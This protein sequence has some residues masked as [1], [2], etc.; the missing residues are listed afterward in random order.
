[1]DLETITDELRAAPLPPNDALRAAV[2]HAAALAPLVLDRLERFRL[3]V[4]LLPGDQRLLLYG[5]HVLAAARQQELWPHL[6]DLARAPE[7]ELADLFDNHAPITLARLM[8]SVWDGDGA[9]LLN[10]IEHADMSD[11]SKWALFDMLAQLTFDGRVPRETT[12]AFLARYERDGLVDDD[13]PL[14]WGWDGCVTRLGLVELEDALHRVWA[15]PAYA[16]LTPGDRESSVEELRRAAASPA[17]PTLFDTI[18]LAP[19]DDPALALEWMNSRAAI[20]GSW[21]AAEPEPTIEDAR[22]PA[23]GVRLSDEELAWLGRFLVSRQVPA[24]TMTLDMLDGYLTAATIGPVARSDAELLKN[25]WSEDEAAAPQWDGDDQQVHV[26][27]LIERHCRAI[28]LRC[29]ASSRHAPFI[30]PAP[31]NPDQL[32]MGWVDGFAHAL[33]QSGEA[34]DPLFADR[35]GAEEALELL[36]LYPDDREY[37]GR[38]AT[39]NEKARIVERLPDILK[40]IAAYWRDPARRYP[41]SV[42][43]R[44]AKTGR[45]D[46]C[47]CGSGKKYKKCCAQTPPAL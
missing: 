11:D 27:G 6:V 2:V 39:A 30:P 15:K 13:S 41:G 31:G 5:L 14:W 7:D 20:Y 36:A 26:S 43:V 40:R 28:R 22:D 12:C 3:G 10:L 46:P 8:L 17:D 37:F 24:T 25:I 18:S 29:E 32:G 35:R 9:A 44:V 38:P 19:V 42:P 47:P 1:M 23:R 4:C 21:R 33:E 16:D 34:W 45:N